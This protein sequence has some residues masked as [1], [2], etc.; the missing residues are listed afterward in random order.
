M[1]KCFGA[2]ATVFFLLSIPPATLAQGKPEKERIR[3]GYSSSTVSMSIPFAAVQAGF[4]REEGIQAEVIRTAGSIAPMVLIAK[5]TEFSIMSALLLIPASIRHGDLVMLGGF[6]SRFAG[7]VLVSRPEIRRADDLRGKIVGVQ[8][9]G[10]AFDI[11][12]R[13]SL[14]HLG[15]DP[16]RDVKLLYLGDSPLLW[17]AL[18]T[19]KVAAALL[20][21]PRTVW[22]RKA[23]MNF[24]VITSDLKVHFQGASITAHRT[25]IKNHPNLTHRVLRAMVRGVHLL[26]TRREEGIRILGKFLGT[27]DREALEETYNFYV[28]ELPVKPYVVESS[29]QAVLNHLAKVDP[30]YGERKPADF[31]DA[32]PLS[33]VDRSGVIERLYSNR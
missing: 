9:P 11:N 6:S 8:R 31:I 5:E 23:G 4:F 3:I 18:E 2:A 19:G 21:P 20:S 10:D 13:I 24:L 25:F 17:P 26:R 22:A 1:T 27:D 7:Q 29:V 14:R 30:R 16:D 32:G 12:T 15:L 28:P 33:E